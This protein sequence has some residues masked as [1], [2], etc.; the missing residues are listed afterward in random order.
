MF[1]FFLHKKFWL[2]W[3]ILVLLAVI[4]EIMLRLGAWN[5]LMHPRSFVKNAV[6]RVAAAKKTGLENID[7]ISVGNSSFDWGTNHGKIRQLMRR[8]HRQYLRFGFE[9]GGFMSMQ[10]STDWAIDKM[11]HL[12]GIIIG[13]PLRDF[14]SFN[15]P[16]KTY[17][18]SWPFLEA[19]DPDRYHYFRQWHKPFSWPFKTAIGIFGPDIVDFLHHPLKRLRLIKSLKD[20]TS[21]ENILNYN[22]KMPKNLCFLDLTDLAACVNTAKKLKTKT[23]VSGPEKFIRNVCGSADA[24]RRAKKNLP[25]ISLPEAEEKRLTENWINFFDHILKEKKQINLV[26]MPEHH[27]MN[28]AV[29]KPN[30]LKIFAQAVE[31]YEG[32]PDFNV[33]DLRDLFASQNT[34]PECMLFNDP[35]H[36][37]DN[38]KALFS[39]ALTKAL[40]SVLKSSAGRE[41]D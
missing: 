39:K 20:L 25:V 15:N 24:I 8:H 13:M 2:T 21:T 18:V 37:N 7:W 22:R 32:N 5:P 3:L 33:I 17:Q 11:P 28:Y 38:G 9:S 30:A 19:M 41:V 6:T 1:A 40:E 16:I 34:M 12:K 10:T 29:R 35:L 27:F 31:K 36:Y 14:S 26:L 23:R 4:L